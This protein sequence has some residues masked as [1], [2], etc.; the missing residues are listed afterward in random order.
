MVRMTQ[1]AYLHK[2][3]VLDLEVITVL[4]DIANQTVILCQFMIMMG[5]QLCVEWEEKE[6]SC[7]AGAREF[8]LDGPLY[9]KAKKQTELQVEADH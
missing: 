1:A 7:E 4:S 2:T 3:I 8:K 9:E 5:L 6:A